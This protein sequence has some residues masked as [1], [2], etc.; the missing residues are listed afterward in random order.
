LLTKPRTVSVASVER[1]HATAAPTE[2][3]LKLIDSG[4]VVRSARRPDLA[5]TT[6]RLAM[7]L[8]LDAGGL[9]HIAEALLGQWLAIGTADISQ[10]ADRSCIQRGLQ[11]RKNGQGD[12]EADIWKIASDR[13]YSGK[14]IAMLHGWGPVW[15]RL[16]KRLPRC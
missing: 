2:Q 10:L 7:H 15:Q 4:T 6:R 3:R 8:R 1:R 14:L 9:E 16:Y 5:Q 13:V 12:R 11:D